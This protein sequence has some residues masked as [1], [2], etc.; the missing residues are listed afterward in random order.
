MKADRGPAVLVKPIV[1]EVYRGGSE[2]Q[3]IQTTGQDRAASV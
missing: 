3:Q 2:S 1:Q